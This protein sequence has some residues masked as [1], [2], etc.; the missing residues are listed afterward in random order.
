MP[1]T[2]AIAARLS[3]GQAPIDDNTKTLLLAA[4][5]L[6]GAA[7]LVATGRAAV[8][9]ATEKVASEGQRLALLAG[10]WVAVFLAA[11]AILVA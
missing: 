6:L 7:G 3:T 1:L 9:S 10:F 4:L 11:R 8:A 5:G 2:D